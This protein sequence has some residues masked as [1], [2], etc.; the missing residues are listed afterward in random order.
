MNLKHQKT[1][2]LILLVEICNSD[3][4]MQCQLTFSCYTTSTKLVFCAHV[5]MDITGKTYVVTGG[6]SGL[7]EG[8][9]RELLAKGANVVLFD[10]DTK[11][12]QKLTEEFNTGRDRERAVFCLVDVTK[13]GNCNSVSLYIKEDIQAGIQRGVAKF[14]DIHGVINCAGIGIAQKVR[15]W[16]SL[17]PDL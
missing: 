15:E 11:K 5:L 6:A 17:V 4:N 16:F 3:L 13:T 1:S 12:G 14:G 7:G 9:A 8:T 10:R 2:E